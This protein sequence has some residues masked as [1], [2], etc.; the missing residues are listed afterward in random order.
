M[1]KPAKE[2]RK[3]DVVKLEFGGAPFPTDHEVLSVYQE[4]GT[5]VGVVKMMYGSESIRF[6]ENEIVEVVE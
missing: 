2:L 1:N 4:N 3:G 6:N 5:V